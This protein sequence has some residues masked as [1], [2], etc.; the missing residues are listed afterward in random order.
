M[1]HIIPSIFDRKKIARHRERGDLTRLEKLLTWSS[2]ELVTRLDL[3]KRHFDIITEVGTQGD[4]LYTLLKK[5]YAFK[6][7]IQ[8]DFIPR[9]SQKEPPY[10]QMDEEWLPFN[11]QSVDLML[12]HL[13]W[14]F[15]NDLPGFLRQAR[16]ALKP[17][18]L[19]LGVMFGENTLNEL[20]QS[21]FKAQQELYGGVTPMTAPMVTA[22]Q[23]GDLLLR[24]GFA[25]PV[26]E[27]HTLHIHYASLFD[28]LKDIQA[29]GAQAS[30]YQTN[31]HQ[32]GHFLSK[33]LLVKTED[34]YTHHF[35]TPDG[36]LNVTLDFLFVSGWAPHASQP[37]ALPPHHAPNRL[38]EVL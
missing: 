1:K 34:I 20:S 29:L 18:G 13:T 27:K 28:L 15:Q 30:L 33:K 37:K 24:A 6:H 10:I 36:K 23:M 38:I 16:Y 31:I 19:I 11:G 32:K 2:H 12:G 35:S 17:D 26:V 5:S 8:G 3:V 22:Y 4:Y 14:H 21:F 25:L 7:Y 9:Q